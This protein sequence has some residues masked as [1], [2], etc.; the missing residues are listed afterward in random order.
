[1]AAPSGPRTYCPGGNDPKEASVVLRLSRMAL[2]DGGRDRMPRLASLAELGEPARHDVDVNGAGWLSTQMLPLL[3]VRCGPFEEPLMSSGERPDSS[4]KRRGHEA[5]IGLSPR[6]TSA[7]GGGDA[8]LSSGRDE[9]A[10]PRPWLGAR[11]RH[12]GHP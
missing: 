2:G 9:E 4:I 1:M 3:A 6:T 11:S 8:E 7:H 10:H 5:G 12:P